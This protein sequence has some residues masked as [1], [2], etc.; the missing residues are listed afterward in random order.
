MKSIYPVFMGAAAGT[1]LILSVG[2]LGLTYYMDA[3]MRR[4]SQH[5]DA[6]DQS[7]TETSNALADQ[8]K[9]WSLR[10]TTISEKLDRLP[11]VA[12]EYPLVFDDGAP[13]I[14]TNEIDAA[15]QEMKS[16]CRKR[17]STRALC[18]AVFDAHWHGIKE[19][20]PVTID[21]NYQR[22]RP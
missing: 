14:H 15:E 6:A 18:K 20:G 5:L 19:Y 3:Q 17:S 7:L 12:L 16:I 8:M 4:I 9:T 10:D 1:G 22:F 11:E 21:N 2:L 13:R